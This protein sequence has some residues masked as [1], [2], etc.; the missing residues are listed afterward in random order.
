MLSRYQKNSHFL[1]FKV[2]QLEVY[3]GGNECQV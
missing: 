2:D 1:D 3:L